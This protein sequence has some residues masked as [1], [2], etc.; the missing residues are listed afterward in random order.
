MSKEGNAQS[1]IGYHQLFNIDP[2]E[3]R[4]ERTV[5]EADN[6]RYLLQ[7]ARVCVLTCHRMYKRRVGNGRM[8]CHR[9]LPAV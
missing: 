5:L 2:L 6:E 8:T 3:A 9:S 1:Q 4:L 7:L